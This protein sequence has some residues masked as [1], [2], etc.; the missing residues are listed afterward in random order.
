MIKFIY[1]A[2]TVLL[3]ARTRAAAVLL[4]SLAALALVGCSTTKP[5]KLP[6]V[7]GENPT[8]TE[9][10]DAVNANSAKIQSI[11]ATNASIGARSSPGWANCQLFFSRPSNLRLVGTATIVG[12]VVDC[13]CDGEKFWF[14]SSLGSDSDS[15][16]Y[17]RLDEYQ[18]S[19]AS[20]LLPV[21][22]SWF[23][24]AFGVVDIK[25][26]EIVD[27]LRVQADGSFLLTV[28]K[29][30][31]D[32]VYTKRIYLEPKS[33]AIRRQDVQNPKGDPVLTVE[34]LEQQYLEAE[35][36]VMPKKLEITCA[37]TGDVLWVDLGAPT[38]NDA[39]KV[40]ANVFQMPTDLKATA[41]NLGK[42]GNATP[43]ALAPALPPAGSAPPANVAWNPPANTTPL[44]PPAQTSQPIQP[45]QQSVPP[46][47][48]RSPNSDP[49][50][51]AFPSPAANAGQAPGR[52][53]VDAPAAS[54][55]ASPLASPAAS[56]ASRP[57]VVL[58]SSVIDDTAPSALPSL[59][60][61]GNA[62]NDAALFPQNSA[63][64]PLPS[65]SARVLVYDRDAASLANSNSTNVLVPE[66]AAVVQS[67]VAQAPAAQSP[68]VQSPVAQ[69]PQTPPV[70]AAPDVNLSLSS[71]GAVGTA[72]PSR[73]VPAQSN[74]P[75]SN[76]PSLAQR[77]PARLDAP[78]QRPSAPAQP[79][80]APSFRAPAGVASEVAL[81]Q[82]AA[83]NLASQAANAI[84]APEPALPLLDEPELAEPEPAAP[85][86]P[87]FPELDDELLTF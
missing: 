72:A 68:A 61:L 52:I 34:C 82:G 66:T 75:N 84:P 30:R 59:A 24:E 60:S 63:A 8:S 57:A 13:G 19:S 28:K 22:P 6:Q 43:Q 9:L 31:P 36:V 16:Y 25:P 76:A 20:Q 4:T 67:P 79:S 56:T 33:A 42:G 74:A 47:T 5:V 71:L 53:P 15:L 65:A 37:S 18:N 32:G 29:S 62:P 49:G 17:C 55:A 3:C 54:T 77:A 40:E 58:P 83:A 35:G 38:L 27:D 14:W 86:A 45:S 26:E 46:A 21:D 11:Y 44:P 51:V 87:E 81:A 12:R 80:A 78:T 2:F 70:F 7:V 50:L 23:P 69:A 73:A 85:V 48:Y 39:S 1:N 64:Q 10:V 41:V